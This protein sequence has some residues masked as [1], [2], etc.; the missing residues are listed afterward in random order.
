LDAEF[1]VNKK[2]AARNFIDTFVERWSTNVDL[3]SVNHNEIR[4]LN[5]SFVDLEISKSRMTAESFSIKF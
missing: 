3:L 4:Y 1:W 2:T 5:S